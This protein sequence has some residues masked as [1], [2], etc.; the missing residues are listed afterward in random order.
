MRKLINFKNLK[1][2]LFVLYISAV[3]AITLLVYRGSPYAQIELDPIASYRRALNAPLPLA[4]IE[5]RNAVLNILMFVPLGYLLPMLSKKFARLLILLSVAF[6][7]TLSIELLQ[8]VT[9]RGVFS[10]EDMLHNIL[11][12]AIGLLAYKVFNA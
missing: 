11:G 5:I 8:L 12:A 6:L 2:L 3:L 10:I 7:F 1:W 4:R 9:A